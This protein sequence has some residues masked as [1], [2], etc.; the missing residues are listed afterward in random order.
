MKTSTWTTA[1]ICNNRPRKLK[2]RKGV[3]HLPSHCNRDIMAVVVEALAFAGAFFI[4]Y[5]ISPS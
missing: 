3:Y 5:N 1:Q 2:K 4:W